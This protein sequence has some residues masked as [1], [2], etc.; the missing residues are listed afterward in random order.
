[1]DNIIDK[2]IKIR[3]RL[4]RQRKRKRKKADNAKGLLSARWKLCSKA[5]SSRCR[6]YIR[7]TREGPQK[8][9]KHR[10]KRKKNLNKKKEKRERERES[11]EKERKGRKSQRNQKYDN[12]VRG[13]SFRPAGAPRK[14]RQAEK[15]AR[16]KQKR[17]EAY[18]EERLEE[19]DRGR[20]GEEGLKLLADISSGKQAR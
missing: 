15:S 8:K 18:E 3:I 11:K 10:G 14:I 5:G 9:K 1:M 20:S 4:K 6:R 16:W 2:S 12:G 7:K 19:E 13:K 17:K